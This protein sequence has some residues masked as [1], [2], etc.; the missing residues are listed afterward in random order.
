MLISDKPKDQP[1]AK[2]NVLNDY[3]LYTP[4]FTLACLGK[5]ALANPDSYRQSSLDF[6]ILKSGGKNKGFNVNASQGVVSVSTSSNETLDAKK[7]VAGFN[8]ESPGRFDMFMDNVEFDCLMTA[9]EKQGSS[10]ALQIKFEVFEPYSLNGFIEALHVGA[11]SAGFN[12]YTE[13]SYLL[14]VEFWGYSD[15][16]DFSTPEL[17]PNASRY[18]VFNFT[19]V[20]VTVTEQGTK[21]ICTGVPNGDIA[22]AEPDKIL[23]DIKM[24]GATVKEVLTSLF[25]SLNKTLNNRA[26]AEKGADKK[27]NHDTYEI[28]FPD[29]AKTGEE[30]DYST[31]SVIAKAKMAPLLTTNSIFK[32][33]PIE[34]KANTNPGESSQAQAAATDSA[35]SPTPQSQGLKYE[36]TGNSIQFAQNTKISDAITA[37]IRDSTYLENILKDIK[38]NCDEHGRITYFLIGV[39]VIPKNQ[40]D[41]ISQVDLN[42]YRYVVIPYKVHFSRFPLQKGVAWDPEDLMPAVNRIY[43]YIYTGKNVDVLNF[44]LKF[45]NLFFQAIPPKA[46]NEKNQEAATAAGQGNTT[47]VS[48]P[49]SE[50]PQSNKEVIPSSKI[51]ASSAA[52]GKVSDTRANRAGP[53]RTDPYYKFAEYAHNAILESVDQCTADLD[54]IGDPFYLVMGGIGNHK[55]KKA[56]EGLTFD[57]TADNQSGDVVIRVNFKNPD[58]IDPATGF[59]RFNPSIVPYSGIYKVLQV[60]SSF[61]DGGFKQTLNLIRLPGQISDD[62]VT[63]EEPIELVSKPKKGSQVVTDTAPAGVDKEGARPSEF[64]ITKLLSRGFPSV[65]LPGNLSDFSAS[66][67]LAAVGSI[68]ALGVAAL[69]K[70]SGAIGA[71]GNLAGIASQVG[72]PVGSSLNGL[73][74]LTNGIRA[75]AVTLNGVSNVAAG[76][77]ALISGAGASL[78]S[79][80]TIANPAASIA[81]TLGVSNVVNLASPATAI[82]AIGDKAKA[83]L[84]GL[85]NDPSAAMA[86]AGVNPAQLAGLSPELQGKVKDQIAQVTKDLPPDA[87]LAKLKESGVSLANIPADRIQ[88]LPATAKK[89]IASV[90]DLPDVIKPEALN[91]LNRLNAAQLASGKLGDVTAL[92]GKFSSAQS[93]VNSAA[94]GALGGAESALNKVTSIT[95]GNPLGGI[96]DG[97]IAD[98]KN[99]VT[100]KFGSNALKTPS[101]LDSLVANAGNNTWS[102]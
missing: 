14:K 33:V 58:D 43:N 4:S 5:S 65:G 93:L 8:V 91:N 62:S 49:K 34:K 15:K 19:G 3:R 54:I 27:S 78:G 102:I 31:E 56:S 79:L 94:G 80:S 87:D 10:T 46:G 1:G 60:K 21:Y 52:D 59:A 81:K 89:L 51:I 36:P 25:D 88:N 22:L 76:T 100:A 6:V 69:S 101:P 32:M 47:Q 16:G 83:A 41:S 86:A 44:Q 95:G 98:L 9:G 74:A 28:K 7:L 57:S 11:V 24:T 53:P 13:A 64:S 96:S 37:V 82:S 72:V 70:V 38:G 17:V 84:N 23:T 90:P 48:V 42:T 66:G 29:L 45:N 68:G 71:A 30:L 50:S 2:Y 61:K 35:A 12:S 97:S 39:E 85:P 92:A 99:S 20:E 55:P 40:K 26:E 73:N 67:A 63:K 75:N 18:F 77:G